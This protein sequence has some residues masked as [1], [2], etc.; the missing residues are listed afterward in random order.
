M[1]QSTIT[2]NQTS[3]GS[4]GIDNAQHGTLTLTN[5]AV[6]GN[7]GGCSGLGNSDGWVTITNSTFANNNTSGVALS[8]DGTLTLVNTT[9]AEN[10]GGGLSNG[11]TAVLVNTI[12]AGNTSYHSGD[13]AN[14]E[15]AITSQGNNLIGEPSGCTITLLPGASDLTGD[16]GLDMFTDDETP[17]NGHF[18]LLPNSQAIN[19]GNPAACP[20]TDQ[21]WEKRDK[22]CDIGAI[23]FQGKAMSSR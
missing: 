15:G 2:G 8:N 17:G 4:C 3:G 1:S 14:C 7:S 10:I 6:I 19:A 23:E 22:S 11:G 9:I 21:L 5:T 16:P 13:S 20:K 18:P 12:L